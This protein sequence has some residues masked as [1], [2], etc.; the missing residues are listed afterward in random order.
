MAAQ[1]EPDEAA[2]DTS[3]SAHQP[4]LPQKPLPLT[5]TQRVFGIPELLEQILLKL[6]PLELIATP[7]VNRFWREVVTD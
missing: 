2:S 7:H 4:P 5:A 3:S 6:G 1:D